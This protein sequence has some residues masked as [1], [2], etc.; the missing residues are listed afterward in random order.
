MQ[1]ECQFHPDKQ[2]EQCRKPASRKVWVAGEY[3]WICDRCWPQAIIHW[4]GRW[5]Y[6]L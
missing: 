3:M 5:E 4:E 6:E 1:H 2:S